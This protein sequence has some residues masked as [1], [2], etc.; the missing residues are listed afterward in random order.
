MFECVY[1]LILYMYIYTYLYIIFCTYTYTYTY[2]YYYVFYV[3]KYCIVFY[4]IIVDKSAYT[5]M[6]AANT[7]FRT[8]DANRSQN[9]STR[10]QCNCSTGV[11]S[12]TPRIHLFARH[13]FCD[14]SATCFWDVRACFKVFHHHSTHWNFWG[15]TLVVHD[16]PHPTST[17]K[18]G[19]YWSFSWIFSSH[20]PPL[21]GL[22]LFSAHVFRRRCHQR[23]P[24]SCP[25]AVRCRAPAKRGHGRSAAQCGRVE[26]LHQLYRIETEVTLVIWGVP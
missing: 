17:F 8:T 1:Y 18:L 14:L 3:I 19:L 11:L 24:K 5:W 2:I 4:Y 7:F 15:F 12:W 21:S 26:Q 6:D 22:S 16:F 23:L 10:F 13:V 20:P 9:I 25:V